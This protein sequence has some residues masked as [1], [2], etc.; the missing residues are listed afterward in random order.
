MDSSS[1]LSS[2]S[3]SS[4]PD[5]Q[6]LSYSASPRPPRPPRLSLRSPELQA[7]FLKEC[8]NRIRSHSNAEA[9]TGSAP[10]SPAPFSPAPLSSS[11]SSVRLSLSSPELL[12]ELR[13]SRSLRPVRTHPGLT[14]VFCGRGRGGQVSGSAPST[15]SANQKPSH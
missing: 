7:E 5:S 4:S 14:T 6:L 13:E 15:R 11:S 10:F 1:S 3:S 12:T 2:S 8:S 9:S